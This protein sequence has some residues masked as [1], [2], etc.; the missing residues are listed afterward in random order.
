MGEDAA[1][2]V[3]ETRP[4]LADQ[5]AMLTRRKER[6]IEALLAGASRSA[7][8]AAAGVS[9]RTLR[10]WSHEE[11]FQAAL[12]QAQGRAFDA[13]LGELRGSALDGVR[14][15]REVATD[16]TAPHAA[17]VTAAR[18]LLEEARRAVE[19]DDLEA[20][21]VTLERSLGEHHA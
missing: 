7:A 9:E 13:A 11:T 12:R 19:L 14:V 4:E 3:G 5:T 10:R 21:I 15:L 1:A 2:N 8:A 20:R 6:A 16:A 17:R 18:A